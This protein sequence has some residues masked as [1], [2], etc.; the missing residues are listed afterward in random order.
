M[1]ETYYAMKRSLG[2]EKFTVRDKLCLHWRP[3][4]GCNIH[5]EI[6]GKRRGN[7]L[8]K[9][10]CFSSNNYKFHKKATLIYWRTHPKEW[11]A[12]LAKVYPK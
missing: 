8:F 10:Y 3:T 1:N 4:P 9:R 12:I 6:V 7:I 5:K 11:A 2:G